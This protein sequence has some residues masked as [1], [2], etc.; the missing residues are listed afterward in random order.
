MRGTANLSHGGD[1]I[2]S[3]LTTVFLAVANGT[4]S[5]Q[6]LARLLNKAPSTIHRQLRQLRE[7]GLIDW[8]DGHHGSLH[9]LVHPVT[10]LL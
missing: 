8:R 3:E 10:P 9:V 2:S 7:L 6:G 1:M 4:H 5:V